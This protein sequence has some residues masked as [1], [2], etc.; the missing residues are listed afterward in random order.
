MYNDFTIVDVEFDSL[1]ECNEY[2]ETMGHLF[3]MSNDKSLNPSP[4]KKNGIW[5]LEVTH[6]L[7]EK[8]YEG[9]QII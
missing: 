5:C 7:V 3:A 2:A 8:D 6:W 4:I 1:E 9:E